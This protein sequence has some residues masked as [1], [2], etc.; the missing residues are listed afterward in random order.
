MF[1]FMTHR[2]KDSYNFKAAFYK[3]VLPQFKNGLCR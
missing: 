2:I 1:V 3:N